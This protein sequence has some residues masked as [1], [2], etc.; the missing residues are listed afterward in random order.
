MSGAEESV[1]CAQ[2]DGIFAACACGLVLGAAV[3]C[4]LAASSAP[5]RRR[6]D[7][8]FGCIVFHGMLRGAVCAVCRHF[9]QRM[10]GFLPIVMAIGGIFWELTGG[11]GVRRFYKWAHTRLAARKFAKKPVK[12][13]NKSFLF[14]GCGIE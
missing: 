3:R 10:R 4:V 14:A 7:V 11:R 8:S 6:T 1:V 9:Q 12:N 13:K 2:L 5:A